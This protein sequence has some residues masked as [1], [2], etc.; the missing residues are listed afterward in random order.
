[1]WECRHK[2]SRMHRDAQRVSGLDMLM[3]VLI[4]NEQVQEVFEICIWWTPELSPCRRQDHLKAQI[5][6]SSGKCSQSHSVIFQ[7]QPFFHS[8]SRFLVSGASRHTTCVLIPTPELQV[9]ERSQTPWGC[10]ALDRTQTLL[11][12]VLPSVVI[13]PQ[14]TMTA[15]R[16]GVGGWGGLSP[17]LTDERGLPWSHA[18]QL[19]EKEISVN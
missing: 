8:V 18:L 4:N 13:A 7:P 14:I 17:P 6:F 9:L 11:A 3:M 1:M 12:E 19:A 16:R 2:L 10:H 15:G 5:S